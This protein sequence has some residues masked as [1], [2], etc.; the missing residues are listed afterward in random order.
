MVQSTIFIVDDSLRVL[1]STAIMLRS[2]GFRVETFDDPACFLAQ[3]DPEC[4]GVVLLDLRM[5]SIA[6]LD[7]LGQ[8][9]ERGSEMPVLFLSAD[10]EID[11]V[12]RAMKQGARDFI[13]KPAREE[14]LVS[15]L[16]AAIEA[17]YEAG[18]G[19]AA[20]RE[21]LVAIQSLSRRE[22]EVL[23]MVIQG[24]TNREIGDAL[25]ITEKTVESHRTKV[26]KKTE[27]KNAV[28]LTS[29]VLLAGYRPQWMNGSTFLGA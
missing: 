9:R 24:Q 25:G 27:A 1:E 23:D 14:E 7:V 5:P 18:R 21:V 2:F 19:R 6:G 28:E 12:V 22:Q 4:P 20:R 17:D 13:E 11:Q 3:L 15:R 26:Y 8:L 10:A 16:R 29:R